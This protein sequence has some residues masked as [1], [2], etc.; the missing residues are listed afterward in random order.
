MK[1]RSNENLA[2]LLGIGLAGVGVAACSAR[3]PSTVEA[4]FTERANGPM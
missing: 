4:S 2:L 3:T 1:L